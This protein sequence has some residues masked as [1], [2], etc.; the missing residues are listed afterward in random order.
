MKGFQHWHS[1][2]TAWYGWAFRR[3]DPGLGLERLIRGRLQSFDTPLFHG[4]SLVVTSLYSDRKGALWVGTYDR[5]IYR[6]DGDLVEHF[7]RTNGLSGDW[8]L[9]IAG[10]REGD[11]WV[12][13][14]QGVDRFAEAPVATVTVAEG[15]CSAE[16]GSVAASPDGSIW[17]GGD[18]GLTRIRDG[19]VK[20]FRSGREL[21]GSQVTSLFEDHA[22][23]L[24]V[25]LDQGLWVYE[26][27]RFRQITRP[28]AR[29][30][31]L[32]TGIAEDTEQRIWIAAAGPPRILM[33]VEGLM[34]REEC[35]VAA[36]AAS[37]R[38]RLNRRIMARTF[39]TATWHT[40]AMGRLSSIRSSIPK[41]L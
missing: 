15:L 37:R 33:R 39:S 36:N 27:D 31:G 25:G 3:R 11:L 1:R 12:V 29:P 24:W 9:G 30:I 38:A 10:D 13:T 17:T 21:P 26:G 34:V 20:C 23:R 16:A 8:I 32:V 4:S 22:G 19:G 18:G 40:F 2:R 5:G 35:A 41:A 7:D 6:I 28:D 14:T